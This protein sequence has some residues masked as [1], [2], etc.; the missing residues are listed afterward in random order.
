[1]DHTKESKEA[2]YD[3]IK[4]LANSPAFDESNKS[5]LQTYVEEGPFFA[6]PGLEVA[7]MEE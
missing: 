4:R 3:I 2:K 5:R 6:E 1:M 7:M